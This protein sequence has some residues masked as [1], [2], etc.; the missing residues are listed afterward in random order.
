VAR[1]SERDKIEPKVRE[2]CANASKTTPQEMPLS[3][4]GMSQRLNINRAT[5]KK[6]F[7]SLIKEA[8]LKQRANPRSVAHKRKRRE[9]TDMLRDRDQ[10]I[11]ELEHRAKATL[12]LIALIEMNAAR[13][14]INPEE[15]YVPVA[16]P[17]RR[18]SRAGRSG[19]R[20]R[21]SHF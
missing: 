18:V 20:A 9:C 14:G 7:V 11:T 1:P 4:L 17:D 12:A 16:K 3:L 5:L 10:K 19:H 2:Y 8:Q 6:Y 13:L 15:L 21:K